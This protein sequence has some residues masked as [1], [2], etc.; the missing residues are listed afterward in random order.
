MWKPYQIYSTCGRAQSDLNEEL[1]LF[2]R[3]RVEHANASKCRKLE[4]LKVVCPNCRIWQIIQSCKFC[5]IMQGE[6]G[7]AWLLSESFPRKF[8]KRK[9]SKKKVFQESFPKRRF[10]KKV[11]QKKVHR[12]GLCGGCRVTRYVSRVYQAITSLSRRMRWPLLDIFLFDNFFLKQKK[13]YNKKF[14]CSI[15]YVGFGKNGRTVE[16]DWNQFQAEICN[17]KETETTKS[18]KLRECDFEKSPSPGG[19]DK[20]VGRAQIQ[21]IQ[22]CRKEVLIT[23]YHFDQKLHHRCM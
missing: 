19:K 11:F 22:L 23:Q 6:S 8:S 16:W 15:T 21:N 17:K 2:L 10:S 9:L 3:R 12:Q 18:S 1:F 14:C 7:W 4:Y 13:W 5:Q 20:H